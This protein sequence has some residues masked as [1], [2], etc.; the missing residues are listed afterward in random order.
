LIVK[1]VI[2]WAGAIGLGFVT[3]ALPIQWSAGKWTV[4]NVAYQAILEGGWVFKVSLGTNAVLFLL[5]LWQ[6]RAYNRAIDR[7]HRR[8]PQLEEE[9][10]KRRSSSRPQH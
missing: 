4:I 9:L 1:L 2:N 3:I 10:D 6:R 8:V 5:W 7:E